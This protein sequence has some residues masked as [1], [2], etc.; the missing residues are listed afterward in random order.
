MFLGLE[1]LLPL[2]TTCTR[3]LLIVIYPHFKR[4][5]FLLSSLMFFSHI[6][7]SAQQHSPAHLLQLLALVHNHLLPAGTGDLEKSHSDICCRCPFFTMLNK[8][9]T[10][11]AILK[12]NLMPLLQFCTQLCCWVSSREFYLPGILSQFQYFW[13]GDRVFFTLTNGRK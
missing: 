1:H 5:F 11:T 7:S 9:K 10:S 2:W 4:N 3:V 13:K 12:N 6:S 8:L